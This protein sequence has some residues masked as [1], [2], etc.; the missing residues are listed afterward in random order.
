MRR[1]ALR[2]AVVLAAV[3]VT[4]VGLVGTVSYSRDYDLHRGFA[5]VVKLPRAGTGRLLEVHFRSSALHRR[6]DYL[7][8]LPPHYDPARRYPVDYLL[9]G[10]AGQPHVF[11]TIANLDVRLDNQISLGR[12]RPM[13]L[14]FPDGRI[15]GSVYSDSEWANTARGD[16]E[17]YVLEVV[18]DVDHRF[19]TLVDRRDRMI[20]GF[21]AGAY[22]AMNVA[23]HHLGEFAD[24][25]SWSGYFLQTHTGVFAHATPQQLFYNSP[26]EDVRTLGAQLRSDPLRVYAFSGRD[27]D[28][29]RQLAPMVRALRARGVGVTARVYAGG[30]DWS[31]WYPRLNQ[32]LD[33]ASWDFTHPVGTSY[34]APHREAAR[35]ADRG[36]LAIHTGVA[37]N[38]P[39]RRDV[40]AASFALPNLGRLAGGRAGAAPRF[41]A[42]SRAAT[43]PGAGAASQPSATSRAATS[44]AA[45]APAVGPR[46]AHHHSELRLIAALLLALVSAALINLGFVLQ[47]RGRA[48]DLARGRASLAQAL[49][50]RTW[51]GGQAVGWL[52]FASQIVAVAIAPL[53]LVQ[54]FAAGSLAIS[55][56]LAARLFG[57]RIERAQL[58][59]VGVVALSLASLPVGFH[60]THGHP[61]LH[62]GALLLATLLAVAVAAGLSASRRTAAQA[63]AAG[64]MYG[65]ADAA[66]KAEAFALRHH[67]LGALL[68]GW[69]ILAAT[70][71]FA[72]FAA[73]QAA[74][75][76]RDAVKPLSLMNAFT[77]VA[78]MIIGVV[79]FG[80]SIGGS[81]A[82][83]AGHVVA[84]ALVLAC[85]RP[86]AE[87]QAELVGDDEESARTPPLAAAVSTG[88][89]ARAAAGGMARTA[90]RGVAAVLAVLVAVAAGTGL[91]YELRQLRWLAAGP[92]VPDALPLLQLAGFDAQPLA[93]VLAAWL[94]TGLVLGLALHRMPPARRA[95]IVAGLAAVLLLAASDASFA[96]ARNLRL[97]HVLL[98]RQ[99]PLGPWLAWLLLTAAALLPRPLPG[100]GGLATRRLPALP[101]LPP[102]LSRAR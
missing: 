48:Q 81:P 75:R 18:R 51:L 2:V 98:D 84:V 96:L 49:R 86:L 30:H 60:S 26:L 20:G 27:D 40:P 50:N 101:A 56:P 79:A 25:Q 83:T 23:L 78:A 70:C 85:V 41:P 57:H 43:A 90:A 62:P 5:T 9:H 10:M 1:T 39:V 42:T 61:H 67:G 63:V 99:P 8:Y 11:V 59:A 7:V 97:E 89:A 38:K 73:F 77:A 100:L 35:L 14:V 71:T 54:A 46:R 64:V 72:G 19:A 91:L 87:A 53:T 24:V 22:G 88:R 31:V 34:A 47:H 95:V 44:R 15:G 33:L 68:S 45:T 29:T 16:Y 74:L 12:A 58:I 92:R 52:G 55:V 17:S 36:R 6:A 82:A 76:E 32:M 69:T 21:S 65:V 93:R 66:I 3:A 37:A 102:P 94:A 13:I 80:E 4:A 28:A